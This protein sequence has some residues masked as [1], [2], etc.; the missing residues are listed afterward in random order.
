M[1]QWICGRCS[2]VV[3]VRGRSEGG[4]HCSTPILCLPFIVPLLYIL[5]WPYCY[6]VCLGWIARLVQETVC[7]KMCRTVKLR[8]Y[9]W[10]CGDLAVVGE[11]HTHTHT[12]CHT[13]HAL[14]Y[15]TLHYHTTHTLPHH[16]TTHTLPRHTTHTHC[17]TTHIHYHTTHTHSH[18]DT[19]THTH[20]HTHTDAVIQNHRPDGFVHKLSHIDI[21]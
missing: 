10:R 21:F 16:H 9:K 3:A 14:P 18:T 11:P 12:L 8:T 6:S 1:E 4:A 20:T 5:L 2:V 13:T 19:H 17:H 7:G 15:H